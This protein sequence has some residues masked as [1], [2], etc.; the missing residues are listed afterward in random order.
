MSVVFLCVGAAKAGTSWLHS[1]LAVH[2]GCHF[3]SI[4]ELHYFDALDEGT[5]SRNLQRMRARQVALLERTNGGLNAT[6]EQAARIADGGDWMDVLERGGEDIGAYLGYLSEGATSG[7]VVGETTP[8]YAL[9]S[10]DRLARMA[11]MAQD[12]R[13][14]YLM[15]DPVDRLW[16]HVRMI[17]GRRDADGVVSARRCERILSRTISGEESQIVRRSDYAGALKRLAAAVP[18]G[19]LLIEVFEEMV[20]GEGLARICDFLGIG[21]VAPSPAPV[22]AGQALAMS[23]DQ[24]RRAAHWLAPQYE[25]A[26]AALGRM[27]EAWG[28]KV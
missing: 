25:A 17:A 1:Q 20:S 6:P 19:K 23:P 5:M 11:R 15:R 18:G 14:L 4:K 9:L 13:F 2:P 16:S 8:A 26:H 27:P 24:R 3:R 10:A 7:Q 22:H 21:R 28:R 12:V